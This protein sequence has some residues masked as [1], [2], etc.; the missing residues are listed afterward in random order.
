MK[1][2][3]KILLSAVTISLLAPFSIANAL[4]PLADGSD[5]LRDWSGTTLVLTSHTGPTTDA[6]KVMAKEFE[7]ITGA[8]VE[9][10]DESWTDLLAKHQADYAA[11][12]GS[13]DVVTWAYLWGGN[14]VEGGLVDDMEPYMS[15]ELADPNYDMADIPM[16]VQEVY[17]RYRL[18][19][20]PNTEGLWALPYKF[21]VYLAMY[22]TDLF[23]EAGYDTCPATY[24]EL[25]EA[26]AKIK[27]NHPEMDPLAFPMAMGGNFLSSFMAMN[28]GYGAGTPDSWTDGNLFPKMHQ[29]PTVAA[30]KMMKKLMEYMPADALDYDFDKA[31]TAFAQGN[32]AFTVNWNA[33][34]PYVLDPE[35]SAV[36]DKVAFCA[37][38]GGPDGR[39][40]ALGGCVQGISSQS[41]NKDAAFQLI[42]YIS[43]K[44]RGVDFAMN[45]GSVARF[46]TAN[47]S[48]VIAK[49]PF[50]PLLMDILKGY[51]GFGVYRPWPEIEKTMETYFHKVMLGEDPEST[52]LK[53]AQQVYVQAQRGGYNPGATGP[54]PN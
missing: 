40:S 18:A 20:S 49:Y 11:G 51:T 35:S 26:A 52:L 41:E 4:P 42:Q 17:G 25:Y 16:A 27:A 23:E 50:Y 7:E 43:G 8:K 3:K 28:S 48:S 32:A 15:S 53:G 22:R 12:N 39:Y 34:M 10:I 54:K 37:T 14:Y 31:N 6:A 30:A 44:D 46:S 19:S 9:V 38:P 29:A 24:E 33:Y 5:W 13:Y 21:D 36:S 2:L 47:D 1:N 45:G